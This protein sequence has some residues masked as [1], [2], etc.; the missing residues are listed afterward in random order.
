MDISALQAFIAVARHESFSKASEL[1]FVT[2]PAVSKRVSSLEQEL[3]TQLFNRIA[4]QI[5]LTEAGKQLLPRAQ[6]LVAQAEDMQRYASNLSDDIS[7]NLSVA[8]AH[9]VGL[10]RMPPILKEF[11]RRYPNVHLDILF[12]DSDKAFNAVQKGDIE[13]AVITLPTELPD[14]LIKQR[15]WLDSLSVVV[16]L[17]HELA[18]QQAINL[19]Q[20]SEYFCVLPSKDTETHKIVQ[21]EFDQ[22]YLSLRV[23]METNNL[24]T[25]KMLTEAGLGWSVLPQTMLSNSL[26]V[27]DVG[28]VL[29]R[30][31]GLVVHAKRSLSNAAKALKSLIESS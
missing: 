20:L 30:E 1:L 10:H 21:R 9:H 8:I 4:R 18:S 17:D 26:V 5:S 14:K 12:E 29:Q 6:E 11:G 23:Q 13:F 16:G 31:L 27:I 15:V 25:L 28:L 3:G 22:R 2:Q 24:E 7:G 19:L